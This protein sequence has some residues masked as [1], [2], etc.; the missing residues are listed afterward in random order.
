M[1]NVINFYPVLTSGGEVIN[2]H[3]AL[4]SADEVINIHRVL[5]SGCEV[6]KIHCVLTSVG[7]DYKYSLYTNFWRSRL[8]TFVVC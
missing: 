1:V 8:L 5:K 3:C 4:T 2:I 6:I 7:R